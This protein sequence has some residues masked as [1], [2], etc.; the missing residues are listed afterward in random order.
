MVA[1]NP[2]GRPLLL[3]EK[4][5]YQRPKPA[6]GCS[7]YSNGNPPL[8]LEYEI[9]RRQILKWCL[10]AL[11]LVPVLPANG[12]GQT[13]KSATRRSSTPSGKTIARKPIGK[14][15]GFRRSAHLLGGIQRDQFASVRNAH[16]KSVVLLGD[17]NGRTQGT[18]FV[19]S[20][21]HGLI[22][23]NSHVAELYYKHRR[24]S[25]MLNGTRK[26]FRVK[27]VWF[28]PGVR[29]Y[30]RGEKTMVIRSEN[31]ADGPTA[32]MCPDIAVL[33]VDAFMFSLPAE[34]QLA[35]PEEL[36]NLH[37][38]EVRIFGYPKTDTTRWPQAGEIVRA[39]FDKGA[40]R[41]TYNFQFSAR[42][43]DAEN[44]Y[45]QHSIPSIG[46]F[47][48]SPLFLPNGHVVAVHNSTVTKYGRKMGH[49]IRIDCLW[50]LAVHHKL[51][52]KIPVP[53]KARI[54]L[55]RWKVQ[56]PKAAD[57]RKAL[58]MVAEASRL[59]YRHQKYAEGVKKCN[60][61][62]K[63]VKFSR[64]YRVRSDGYTNYWF[65]QNRRLSRTAALKYLKLAAQDA[66]RYSSMA[67]DTKQVDA[68]I[69]LCVTLNNLGDHTLDTSFNQKA[70]DRLD[71]LLKERKNLSKFDQARIHSS[72]GV[73]LSNIGRFQDAVKEHNKAV[74]MYPRN[75]VFLETR[76][77][78]WRAHGYQS[79]AA[80][81]M[82]KAKEI[83]K[84]RQK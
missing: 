17:P 13:G 11:L 72:R 56:N 44:Q 40:V 2:G 66:L 4:W 71:L 32:P 58:A 5:E 49:G 80:A 73:A 75:A 22:V 45:V 37:E 79:R 38:K 57:Y 26:S 83:R 10:A 84:K 18:G 74:D 21:R 19:I 81:D 42:A 24:M 47:S 25:A 43:N 15:P 76:S 6:R 78:F 29:R 16:Q 64:A 63:L 67:P 14:T 77:A 35:R 3:F 60:E 27:R 69:T 68:V 9:M 59:I 82:A 39:T 20:R 53:A 7:V 31:P 1:P 70:L 48:G 23:T 41:N 54:D 8:V 46:G 30:L 62:L 51:T 65:E 55:A 12:Y 61:A 33:Q 50:E 34:M 36:K 52:G 28:H